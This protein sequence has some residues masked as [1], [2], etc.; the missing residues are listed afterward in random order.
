M[1][2]FVIIFEELCK[3]SVIHYYSLES[4]LAVII[5]TLFTDSNLRKQKKYEFEFMTKRNEQH[6]RTLQVTMSNGWP[7]YLE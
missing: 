3:T 6:L 2:V 1:T 5:S 4:H 7:L